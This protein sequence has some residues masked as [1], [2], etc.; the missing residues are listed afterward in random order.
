MDTRAETTCPTCLGVSRGGRIRLTEE[1]ADLLDLLLRD[2]RNEQ[3]QFRRV[4]IDGGVD[5]KPYN[6]RLATVDLALEEVQRT[7]VEMGW[8]HGQ[9][10]RSHA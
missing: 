9:L 2:K 8:S 6:D 10:Q 4:A 1:T 3:L 7:R 5:P